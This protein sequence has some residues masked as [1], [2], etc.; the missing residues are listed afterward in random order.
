M[1]VVLV[2]RLIVLM[3]LIF[4]VEL[5]WVEVVIVLREVHVTLLIRVGF[6]VMTVVLVIIV[7]GSLLF[8]IGIIVVLIF[9][10]RLIGSDAFEITGVAGACVLFAVVVVSGR[11]CL[12]TEVVSVVSGSTLRSCESATSLSV[13]RNLSRI[14]RCWWATRRLVPLSGSTVLRLS[15]SWVGVASPRCI[16]IARLESLIGS[17]T[18]EAT[19][20]IARLGGLTENALLFHEGD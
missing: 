9:F 4:V 8:E 5:R 1:S 17:C 19:L 14:L 11:I 13:G 3:T 7:I 18:D 12:S 2:F 6:V 10:P 15:S 16:G 20:W